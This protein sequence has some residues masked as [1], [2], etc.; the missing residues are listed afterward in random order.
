[1]VE[2]IEVFRVL[3][4]VKT[5]AYVRFVTNYES[6]SIHSFVFELRTYRFPSI[7]IRVVSVEVF[8][9]F[10]GFGSSK[11]YI[12]VVAKGEGYR[13]VTCFSIRWQGGYL[14]P[15]ICF[16]VVFVEVFQHVSTVITKTEVSFAIDSKAY[17]AVTRCSRKISYTSPNVI[18]E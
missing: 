5:T 6:K 4:V 17:S 7:G 3:V 15:G 11:T 1:S 10:L 13:T 18:F 9:G 12:G 8:Q 16:R 14:S 2:R